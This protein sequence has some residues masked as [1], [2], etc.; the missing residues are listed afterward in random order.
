V[1]HGSV[2]HIICAHRFASSALASGR[3]S[4]IR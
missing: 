4:S 3:I 2:E 1:I